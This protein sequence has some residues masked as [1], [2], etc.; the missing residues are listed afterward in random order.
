MRLSPHLISAAAIFLLSACTGTAPKNIGHNHNQ[1]T[2]C[3]TSPNCVSSM[4][5][6]QT[7]SIE[8]LK[9]KGNSEEAFSQLH[10]YLIKEPRV[11][12][13][14][15]K[16]PYIYAEFSSM[17]FRFVDDVEF[18]F[19][20]NQIEVR[21]ASRIGYSDLGVNRER[22]EHIRKQLHSSQKGL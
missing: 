2:P 9:F 20:E 18:F 12:I 6:S 17:V 13:K 5:T 15:A 22:I 4:A 1:L 8:A 11:T 10:N 19:K 16:Y 14:Q 21:S 3:P 7:H